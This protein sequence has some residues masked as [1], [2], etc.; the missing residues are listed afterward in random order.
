MKCI[1]NRVEMTCM[2]DKIVELSNF[3][4]TYDLCEE[5][6]KDETH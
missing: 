5:V 2:S 4:Y 6:I 3:I 1:V